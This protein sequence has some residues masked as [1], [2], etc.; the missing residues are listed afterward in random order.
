MLYGIKVGDTVLVTDEGAGLPI[1]EMGRPD[2]PVGYVAKARW[3]Q[4]QTQLVRCYDAVPVE[5]S[6]EE[7]ALA[8]SKLQF[9]SLPDEAAYGLRAL[10]DE[11][12]PGMGYIGPDDA[13]GAVQS[14]VRYA[15][16]L[17]KCL[18]SHVAQDGWEPPAAPS[19]WA[20]ILPGQEGSGQE[21]PQEWEQPG[22]TNGYAEGD[23]VTHG[24]HLWT[25]TANDNVWEPGAVGAPW[26]DE[27]AYP[28]A[29]EAE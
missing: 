6:A 24:G 15:G 17:Y 12:V 5:G 21:G 27:G 29:E 13:S 25:S 7:A 28:P 23:Q 26:N 18:Q 11:W 8:L 16:E 10:A 1:V 4:T 3:V 20:R 22:S 9:A 2:V 14:R 19:L